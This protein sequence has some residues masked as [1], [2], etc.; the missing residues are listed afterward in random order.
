M[1]LFLTNLFF[2]ANLA[3]I[4]YGNTVGWTASSFLILSSEDSPLPT[5][6]AN[7]SE[8]AWIGAMLAFGGLIGTPIVGWMVDRYG[9]KSS[10]L[11]LAA[12]QIVSYFNA[13]KYFWR[14][15]F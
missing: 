14:N 3:T 12:P 13:C 15:L 11:S 9:R 8:I 1:F 6:P 7:M 10:L 4:G 5:G 2:A